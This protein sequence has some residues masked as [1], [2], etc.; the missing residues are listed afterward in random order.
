MT[1]RGAITLRITKR[2]FQ[3]ETQPES[4]SFLEIMVASNNRKRIKGE[5]ERSHV[6]P[7]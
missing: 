6:S 4:A 2:G 5:Y 3:N 1:E 7:G